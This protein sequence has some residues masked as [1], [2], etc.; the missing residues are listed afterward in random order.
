M[1]AALRPPMIGEIGGERRRAARS[2]AE[3]DRAKGKAG[4]GRRCEMV[5]ARDQ[6]PRIARAETGTRRRS[7]STATC[8][9]AKR[10]CQLRPIL[11]RGEDRGHGWRIQSGE[12]FLHEGNMRAPGGI[13]F[14]I[15]RMVVDDSGHLDIRFGAMCFREPGDAVGERDLCRG[16]RL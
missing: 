2:G 14:E 16:P 4:A 1:R 5:P 13:A 6:V 7:G 8:S 11:L 10:A 3:H 15:D 12:A 9:A